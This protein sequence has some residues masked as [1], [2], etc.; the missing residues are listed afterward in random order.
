MEEYDDLA[1]GPTK[2][3]SLNLSH[4][5]WR[6]VPDLSEFSNRILHLDMSNNQLVSIPESIGNL[7]LLQ[8]LNVSFNQ[9]EVVDGAIGKCV[10]LRRLNLS[11]NRI[12]S[13]PS[14]IG[15]CILLVSNSICSDL[16]AFSEV[17]SYWSLYQKEE[18]IASNNKMTELPLEMLMGMF[19]LAVVDVRNNKLLEIPT[20]LSR[21]VSK[22]DK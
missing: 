17:Y 16:L 8:T 19:V 18:F 15:S 12:Q 11:R 13:L 22:H 6:I 2:D 20:E 4:D 1:A 5:T 9:I 7:I 21:M 10:R 3:G 14:S